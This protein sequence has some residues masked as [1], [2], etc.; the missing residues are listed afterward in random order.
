MYSYCYSVGS[1]LV[2]CRAT[3]PFL[4]F[5]PRRARSPFSTP[6]TPY[7]ECQTGQ[8]AYRPFFLLPARPSARL[9]PRPSLASDPFPVHTTTYLCILV[10][11]YP[12]ICLCALAGRG[13]VRSRC[14]GL[15]ARAWIDVMVVGIMVGNYHW[16]VSVPPIKIGR[17]GARSTCCHLLP[18]VPTGSHWLPFATPPVPHPGLAGPS[19][20]NS[21]VDP[22]P[23]FFPPPLSLKP[24][25]AHSPTP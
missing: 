18:L 25:H 21:V 14:A 22:H 7:L 19:L 8:P 9:F 2:P 13:L 23:M 20:T 12:S 6:S 17:A 10:H 16:R 1:T 11:I 3:R 15:V 4:V 5:P 24:S